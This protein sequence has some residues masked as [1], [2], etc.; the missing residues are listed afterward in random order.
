MLS[1][2]SNRVGFDAATRGRVSQAETERLAAELGVTPDKLLTR[3]KGQA[4]NAEEA[5]AARQILA[6]SDNELVNLAKRIKGLEQ[7][8]DAVGS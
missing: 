1:A 4:L 7:A 2:V 8:G 5:L 6:K 3:R